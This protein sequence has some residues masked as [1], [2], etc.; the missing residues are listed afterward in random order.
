MH[1]A[2]APVK[3]SLLPLILYVQHHEGNFGKNILNKSGMFWSQAMN[4][5][6]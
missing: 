2:C 5:K 3:C 1:M 6:V 4:I